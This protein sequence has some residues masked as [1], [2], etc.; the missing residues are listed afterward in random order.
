MRTELDTVYLLFVFLVKKLRSV[1]SLWGREFACTIKIGS[2]F[3]VV[4]KQLQV[5][6]TIK[7]GSRFKVVLKQLQ[8]S[9]YD[10]KTLLTTI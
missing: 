3:K 6:C 7:I 9:L 4:L 10:K 2:R 8:A 1:A 5:A